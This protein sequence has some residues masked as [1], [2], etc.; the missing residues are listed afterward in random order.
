VLSGGSVERRSHQLDNL[1]EHGGILKV[2]G[3]T[4]SGG[5]LAYHA[6]P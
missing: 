3:N 5:R 4:L 6:S 1:R 2:V